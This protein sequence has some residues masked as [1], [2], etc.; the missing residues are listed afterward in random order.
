MSQESKQQ[1]PLNFQIRV[2]K[3]IF[4]TTVCQSVTC[5]NHYFFHLINL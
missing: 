3:I 1:N 5:I 4:S 2:T